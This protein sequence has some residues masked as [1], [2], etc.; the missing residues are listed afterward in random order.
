MKTVLLVDDDQEL[1]KS[2]G[3]VLDRIGHRVIA[4]SGAQ[5]ALSDLREGAPVDLV[6]AD[7][8]MPEIDGMEFLIQLKRM[9]PKVPVIMLTGYGAVETY[10]KALSIGAF[11]Y[12]NKPV[13]PT[14]LDRIIQAALASAA[15]ERP[16]GR[17]GAGS[18]FDRD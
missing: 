7:Y 6:I 16:A 10:L 17:A 9:L 15:Q 8:C 4:K 13:K 5:A 2:L 3:A 12:V 14:E 1:L 18:A 11:E